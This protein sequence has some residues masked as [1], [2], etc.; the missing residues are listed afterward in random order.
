MGQGPRGSGKHG[1]YKVL[2]LFKANMEAVVF[3]LRKNY[4]VTMAAMVVQD[5]TSVSSRNGR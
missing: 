3:Q 4:H 2:L 1:I 5:V